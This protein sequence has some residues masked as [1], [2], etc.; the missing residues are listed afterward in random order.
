MQWLD[1]LRVFYI[2]KT[3]WNLRKNDNQIKKGKTVVGYKSFDEIQSSEH[4]SSRRFYFNNTR[5]QESVER[6][7]A[8]YAIV[9]ALML[10]FVPYDS[11]DGYVEHSLLA[12]A[13]SSI[14]FSEEILKRK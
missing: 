2:S 1:A 14:F 9:L 11:N 3:N 6:L 13:W 5:L 4:D 7:G 8:N 10:V 12:L